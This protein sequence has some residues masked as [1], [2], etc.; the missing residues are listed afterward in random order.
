MRRKVKVT[1]KK[2]PMSKAHEPFR[3]PYIPGRGGGWS[4]LTTK[5]R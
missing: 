4:R 1:I 3:K 2:D 5:K